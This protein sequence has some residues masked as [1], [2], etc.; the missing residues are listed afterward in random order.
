MR[1]VIERTNGILKGRFR[2]LSR[3]RVLLYHPSKASKIIYTCCVLHNIAVDARLPI[4]ENE[5]EYRENDIN[6]GRFIII[7]NRHTNHFIQIKCGI[8]RKLI[9]YKLFISL[10]FF[11]DPVGNNILQLGR[12]ARNAYVENNFL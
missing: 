10:I 3:H 9:L 8:D 6:I 11:S 2:C 12:A 1:N 7:C 5:I 4:V